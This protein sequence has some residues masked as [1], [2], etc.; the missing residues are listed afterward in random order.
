MDAWFLCPATWPPNRPRRREKEDTSCTVEKKASKEL[1]N[2][3]FR[4]SCGDDT[5]CGCVWQGA[6]KWC[7]VLIDDLVLL[8]FGGACIC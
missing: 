6:F 5:S 8:V 3:C 7:P 4:A 1:E 2:Y